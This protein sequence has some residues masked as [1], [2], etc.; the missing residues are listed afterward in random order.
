MAK[1][2]FEKMRWAQAIIDTLF[3]EARV[4]AAL[5]QVDNVHQS[6]SEALTI[7]GDQKGYENNIREIKELLRDSETEDNA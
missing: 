1:S 6:C 4:F 5:H 2:K 3:G 7:I